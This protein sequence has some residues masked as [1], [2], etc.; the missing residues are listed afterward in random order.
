MTRLTNT[1][2]PAGRPHPPPVGPAQALSLDL[3]TTELQRC[4]WDCLADSFLEDID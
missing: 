3:L 2:G 4:D 1:H